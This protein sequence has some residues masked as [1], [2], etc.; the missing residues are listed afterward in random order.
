MQD[1]D[2][3]HGMAWSCSCGCSWKICLVSIH[4]VGPKMMQTCQIHWQTISN[5]LFSINNH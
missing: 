4:H 2:N 3:Y 5:I 1:N